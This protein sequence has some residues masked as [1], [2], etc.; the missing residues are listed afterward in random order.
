MTTGRNRSI[1]RQVIP[2]P[3]LRRLKQIIA[4]DHEKIQPVM[5]ESAPVARSDRLAGR[6][7]LVTGGS[8]ALGGSIC[9]RLAAEGATLV[10]CGTSDQRMAAVVTS[11]TD[12]GGIASAQRLD[13]TSEEDIARVF[14]QAVADHGR[15]DILVS[16]AGGSARTEAA[17]IV[18]Q[19]TEVIDH[20]LE[21]NLRGTILCVREAARRMIP[22]ARGRIILLSSTIG[23]RGRARFSDYAAAKAG[24]IGFTRSVAMELGPHGITVNCVSPGIVPRNAVTR[25]AAERLAPT[26]WLRSYGLPE[27]VAGVTAF[28]SSPEA[29]FITGQN[30]LVDGGRSLGLKGD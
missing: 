1:W 7:A 16:C 29:D 3:V 27:D 24:I 28:L 15:L 2:G 12:A 13:V 30:L 11:I 10:V 21:V 18:D 26:N 9:R 5:R 22:A 25:E 14:R 8:G 4:A 19:K 23:E 17:D 6:V 20:V